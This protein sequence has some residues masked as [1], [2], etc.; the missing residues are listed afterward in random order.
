[1]IGAIDFM[2]AWRDVCDKSEECV[3]CPIHEACM[4]SPDAQTDTEINNLITAVM[5]EKARR[6]ADAE[7]KNN[8]TDT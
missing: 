6:E 4:E 8:T 3:N 5:T 2:R 7:R 1:M